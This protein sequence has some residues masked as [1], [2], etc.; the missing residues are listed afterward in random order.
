MVSSIGYRCAADFESPLAPDMLMLSDD[1][2]AQ[3][4]SL[5]S[6]EGPR[7]EM[8][9]K[10]GKTSVESNQASKRPAVSVQALSPEDTEALKKRIGRPPKSDRVSV[11]LPQQSPPP[12]QV[13]DAQ[14]TQFP[15]EKPK[16]S[17]TPPPEASPQAPPLEVVRMSPDG[18]V[19]V[20]QGVQIQF[21]QP[22]INIEPGKTKNRPKG[23]T[24]N[25]E[26]A[27]QWRWIDASTLIFEPQSGRMPSATQYTLTVAKGL[28]S[29][30]GTLTPK[31]YRAHFSTP[32][33]EVVR[34]HPRR[35]RDDV[36]TRPVILLFF[37]QPVDAKTVVASTRLTIGAREG[38]PL[39]LATKANIKADPHAARLYPTSNSRH[40]V[41]L[42]PQKPLSSDSEVRL[43]LN[44][45]VW[46]KEGPLPAAAPY[47]AKFQ[48]HG[49]L[50][51]EQIACGGWGDVCRPGEPIS[52]SFTNE[53]ASKGQPKTLA[54][55]EPKV[56]NLNITH[57]QF[58]LTLF[59]DF[60][61]STE[62]K[63]SLSPDIVDEHKQ[64]LGKIKSYPLQIDTPLPS[65]FTPGGRNLA[66]V[67]TKNP[68]LPVFS[69]AIDHLDV[70]VRAVQASDW[71]GWLNESRAR[72]NLVSKMGQRVTNERIAIDSSSNEPTQNL[73]DL[74]PAL[75]KKAY[76][77]AIVEVAGPSGYRDEPITQKHWVVVSDVLL[78]AWHS[79]DNLLFV[80][81][82]RADGSPIANLDVQLNPRGI[83]GRTDDNG[84]V[85]L[86]LPKSNSPGWLTTDNGG[87]LP[88]GMWSRGGGFSASK[89]VKT[90]LSVLTVD[91]RGIYRPGQKAYVKGWV[92]KFDPKSGLKALP[93][94]ALVKYQVRIHRD[95][96][97]T[98]GELKVSK[99]GSFALELDIPPKASLGQAQ[100]E[101]KLSAGGI[102][103]E[104]FH[105]FSVQEFRRNRFEVTLTS[106]QPPHTIGQPV[107]AN[108]SAQAYSGGPVSKAEVRWTVEEQ[109]AYYSPP[110]WDRWKFGQSWPW[111]W[112]ISMR[113]GASQRFE[114][115]TD[116]AGLAQ[117]IIEPLRAL[118]PYPVNLGISA[119]VLDRDRRSVSSQTQVL[120]HPADYY[121]GLRLPKLFL[122]ENE[123]LEPQFVVVDIEGEAQE[124]KGVT[125]SLHP[126][127]GF[128]PTTEVNEP[129]VATCQKTSMTEASFCKFK[130]Q[131]SGRYIL[132]AEVVDENGQKNRTE[133]LIYWSGESPGPDISV[134]S[135]VLELA[136]DKQ[137]YA[138]GDYAKITIRSPI[139][140]PRG[141]WW[142]VADTIQRF[143]PIQLE[144]HTAEI[145]IPITRQLVPNFSVNV[146]FSGMVDGS[147]R[148][149]QGRVVLDAQ[150]KKDILSLKV[151]PSA[152][153]MEP[154]DQA[155][156]NI[157]VLGS[158]DRPEPN[159]E[160]TLAV[161]DEAVLAI[162]QSK[163]PEPAPALW[164]RRQVY[165][166]DWHSRQELILFEDLENQ[167]DG[168]KAKP[169]A[170]TAEFG[171]MSTRMAQAELSSESTAGLTVSEP[172]SVE[173]RKDF[174]PN[175][176]FSARLITDENGKVTAKFKLPDDLT[177]YRVRAIAATKKRAFGRGEA[178]F[179]TQKPLSIESALPRFLS[180]GDIVELPFIVRNRTEELVKFSAAA[181]ATGL[182]I[183]SPEAISASVGPDD[184]V[185]IRFTAETEPGIEAS[186]RAI[187][188]SSTTYV[189]ALEYTLPIYPTITRKAYAEY[190]NITDGHLTR[191]LVAPENAVPN[192][193]GLSIE[194]APTRLLA[195][196]DAYKNVVQY[197]FQGAEQR[198]S[199]LMAIVAAQ[200]FVDI[201]GEKK[202]PPAETHREQL[203]EDLQYLLDNQRPDG[204][205]SFWPR[206]TQPDGFLTA[207]IAH[208]LI[209]L[210]EANAN[211]T[212]QLPDSIA[213]GINPALNRT[214]T[215]LEQL[216]Q[217][218]ATLEI[219]LPAAAGLRAH[220]T[221]VL[222]QV[223]QA[224][225]SEA[226][227]TLE[228]AGGTVKAPAEVLAWLYGAAINS[229]WSAD[230][231]LFQKALSNR[232]DVTAQTAHLNSTY[233]AGE[234]TVLFGQTRADAIYLL[235]RI[236]QKPNDPIIDKLLSGLIAGQQTAG[237]W[238]HTQENAWA[239]LAITEYAKIKEKKAPNFT[240]KAWIGPQLTL[241]ESF[242]ERSAPREVILPTKW[243]NS[244]LS[245]PSLTLG[246]EGHGRMYYR[247]GWTYV[248]EAITASAESHGMS[249]S[250]TYEALD[251]PEDVQKTKEGW[252]VK[253]GARVRIHLEII[254]NGPRHHVA[255]FD[256]LP[257]GFEPLHPEEQS[258][259]L[260]SPAL[261][262]APTIWR[263]WTWDHDNLRD[264][265]AEAFA[266]DLGTGVHNYSYVVQAI[267]P[268]TFS[269]G[270][271]HVEEMY[272]PETYGRSQT[273]LVTIVVTK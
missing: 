72:Q 142:I 254:A 63:I 220:A 272:A 114:S 234:H 28:Q 3:S 1:E 214:L 4:L 93:K 69:T 140:N 112:N 193:G 178:S 255:L 121:I 206:A 210:K 259:I 105:T 81:A 32:R 224:K 64:K 151:S 230:V 226:D 181:V 211:K 208:T 109:Q 244:H 126:N 141:Y 218:L 53:L 169:K 251:K 36:S 187:V 150:S 196:R 44:A 170:A 111:W 148:E 87:F 130:A 76:G 99:H 184:Q 134:K 82:S 262:E 177:R 202:Q 231:K 9:L 143:E 47:R 85:K 180:T 163:W 92:R 176:Y 59:G 273:D 265:G 247:L 125:L 260:P 96:P 90:Q 74:T 100:V 14:P 200:S 17:S 152:R 88:E 194:V 266:T 225:Q 132:R 164:P 62:Y 240:A 179:Y 52:V 250:R 156:I 107:Q 159:A 149:T 51:V 113:S 30:G 172:N 229:K 91:D 199:R 136:P 135:K 147:P 106:N 189:D 248:P 144:G 68:S 8:V 168:L 190:G 79:G 137:D 182:K 153:A 119:Q 15:L 236:Q 221:W 57:N 25:P 23:I 195:A 228:M 133:S 215:W 138:T 117:L 222:S 213:Y 98:K 258:A 27:G 127:P 78:D 207:H 157:E 173:V 80:A 219:P 29:V 16:Q 242:K 86:R 84:L 235:G 233:P 227:A 73:I 60:L 241:N 75:G 257:A 204:G 237:G 124:G 145:E 186:I 192:L 38:P 70:Q 102:N 146:W 171:L 166:Q 97:F 139:P 18:E 120:V 94:G 5:P 252:V 269:A 103:A 65:F 42:I 175:A 31:R 116:V 267:T 201:F 19:V 26:P 197:R 167:L 10:A 58:G 118:E 66:R 162:S 71:P 161:V 246:H 238:Y 54:T 2:R 61:A 212:I 77:L 188:T 110:G 129:A 245:D 183:Q 249:V 11:E 39:T 22:V 49:S 191:G 203:L 101:L 216:P 261:A 256:R 6:E 223:G 268:G 271:A 131:P 165:L 41:A 37:N 45:G 155:I 55:V 264:T 46:S 13:S 89:K 122:G 198:A 217:Y 115:E 270:A 239:L 95:K 160:V 48:T 56:Q 21:S 205:W 104:H 232:L 185:E 7:L 12:P 128:S 209:L 253:A 35:T 20:A 50:T 123:S 43:V 154:G 174:R 34:I 263:W 33:P 67:L 24:L 243:L 83:K 40:V 108:L 158:D